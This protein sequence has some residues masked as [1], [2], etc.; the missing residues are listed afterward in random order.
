MADRFNAKFTQRTPEESAEIKRRVQDWWLAD[1][2]EPPGVRVGKKKLAARLGVDPSYIRNLIR[3]FKK[4]PDRALQPV[5]ESKSSFQELADKVLSANPIP[6]ASN[7]APTWTAPSVPNL[8]D[9]NRNLS[10]HTQAATMEQWQM[11]AKRR[12]PCRGF[13]PVFTTKTL[14]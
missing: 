4:S 6:A 7:I 3:L 13:A 12:D 11:V 2:E 10:G 8:E 5:S 9:I 14:Y 1:K